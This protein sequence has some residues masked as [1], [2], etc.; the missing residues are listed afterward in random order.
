MKKNLRPAGILIAVLLLVLGGATIAAFTLLPQ[1]S[2]LQ[3]VTIGGP[4]ELTSADGKSFSSSELAGRPYLVFF[5]YTHCPD[6]CPTALQDISQVFKLLGPD[7]KINVVFITV[8]PERDTPEVMKDYVSSF[9]P[10]VI[11]LTGTLPETQAVEKEFR[12]YARKAPTSGGDYLMDHSGIVYLM[13]KQGH[14]AGAF[15]LDAPPQEAA[16]KLAAYL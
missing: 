16:K 3:P 4:F 2:T 1:K 10:R 7:T 5:G 6:F 13:D 12:V 11:A 9:D 15:N 8:D 14:F